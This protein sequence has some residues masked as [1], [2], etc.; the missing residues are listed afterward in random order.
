LKYDEVR[1]LRRPNMGV[2][3]TFWMEWLDREPEC[4]GPWNERSTTKG[5]G[6]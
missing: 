6:K 5:P 3:G 1:A 2:F 4:T